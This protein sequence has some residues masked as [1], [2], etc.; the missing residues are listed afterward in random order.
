MKIVHI[1]KLPDGGASWCAMRISHALT[2][3]GIDS[4]MLLMQGRPNQNISIADID[5]LYKEHKNILVRLVMKVIRLILRPKFERLIYLRKKAARNNNTTF[6]T[7]PIT[8][9]TNIINHPL[10]KEA[11]IIHLHWISDFI[12]FPS[13]FKKVN[14]PIV[15][16]IH[17]ENPGLG[18][19]HYRMH[20]KEASQEYLLLDKKYEDIK[21]KAING[22][23]RPHLI[24]ISNIMYSFLIRNNILG[25]CP[26]SLIHNGVD[27]NLF[28]PISPL[29]CK[30][31]F[32]LSFNKKIFL[33]SSFQ[34]EDERKGLNILIS[35][36][37]ALN[38]N[39]IILICIGN[40][41]AIPKSNNIEIRCT[42]LIKDYEILSKYYSASD[43][44][45]L[46]SLQESFAQT[47]LEAMACGT[48]VIAFPC[49]CIPELINKT[50]GIKCKDF[51]IDALYEGIT[52]ALNSTYHRE[53]IR[54]DVSSRF[55]YDV[56]AKQYMDLYRKILNKSTI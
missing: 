3:Q 44:F 55:S 7:S 29:Q 53:D 8:A 21:R 20:K 39:N 35:A 4:K 32:G 48:P 9:Y 49:G 16:T 45:V 28:H 25:N 27:C 51:T 2:Q 18:G 43:F 17:D 6:F 41:K 50:N 46:S 19:F 54:K 10:I 1:T 24:A 30:K 52:L 14:K 33:F 38:D 26:I 22:K 47:P 13:F 15:W 34:I 12:D 31:E 42:G 40:Y 23:N 36:L 11:D 56:I 37:D 5:W